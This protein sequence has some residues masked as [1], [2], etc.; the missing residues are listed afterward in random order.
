MQAKCLAILAPT[1]STVIGTGMAS[2]IYYFGS[3]EK[4]DSR[5][6]LIKKYDME[7]YCLAIVIF[8]LTSNW[9]NL[10]PVRFKNAVLGGEKYGNNLRTNNFIYKLATDGDEGSAV[11]LH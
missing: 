5:I 9:M 10:Y 8:A 4:Y 3:T 1:L 6:G 7:W 11:V 2:A